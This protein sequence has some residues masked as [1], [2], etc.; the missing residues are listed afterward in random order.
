MKLRYVVPVC[1]ALA[2]GAGLSISALAQAPADTPTAAVPVPYQPSMGDL[3]NIG[4]QPRHIKL[5][6][7]GKQRNWTYASYELD[8]LRN[9]FT[10]VGRT[11]PVYRTLDIPALTTAFMGASLDAL[12][13]AIKSNDAKAF[14]TA[15]RRLT[16]SCNA[17][18]QGSQHDM[19]V[20]KVPDANAYVDQEFRPKAH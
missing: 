16:D 15:Y 11:V 17:C 6:L 7:A 5:W 13:M 19:V 9:A 3:M 2:A 10:R 20:V 18:H 4:V 1:I 14:T 12:E 8:E